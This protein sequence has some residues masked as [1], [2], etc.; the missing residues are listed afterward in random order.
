MYMY[1]Y[2]EF[3]FFLYQY[4]SIYICQTNRQIEEKRTKKLSHYK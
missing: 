4:I 1:I 2:M 3:T